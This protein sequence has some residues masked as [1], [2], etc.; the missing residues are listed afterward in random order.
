M[1]QEEFKVGDKVRVIFFDAEATIT[2]RDGDRYTA[3][4]TKPQMVK[5]LDVCSTLRLVHDPVA[6]YG[7][8]ECTAYHLEKI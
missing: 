1:K 7:S 8:V 2:A 5:F 4:L 3:K 6:Y